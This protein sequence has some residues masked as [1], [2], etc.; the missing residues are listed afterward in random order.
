MIGLLVRA[1]IADIGEKVTNWGTDAC[2]TTVAVGTAVG[3]DIPTRGGVTV[4][5]AVGE[6]IVGS[7]P[8]ARKTGEGEGRSMSNIRARKPSF[9]WL[10]PSQSPVVCP[11]M[12]IRPLNPVAAASILSKF[13]VPS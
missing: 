12:I 6:G 13:A 1:D 4:G 8:G 5:V 10:M 7:M 3:E 2:G 9:P 11:A